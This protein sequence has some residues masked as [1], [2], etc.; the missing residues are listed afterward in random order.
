MSLLPFHFFRPDSRV[1]LDIFEIDFMAPQAR[2][3]AAKMSKAVEYKSRKQAESGRKDKKEFL[4]AQEQADKI[5]SGRAA[6]EKK[7]VFA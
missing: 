1:N 3:A 5:A 7:R 2:L 4:D 6:L